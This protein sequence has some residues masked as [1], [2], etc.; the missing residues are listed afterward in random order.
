MMHAQ[1]ACQLQFWSLALLAGLVLVV[2]WGLR[3]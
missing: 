3:R 1:I 2:M